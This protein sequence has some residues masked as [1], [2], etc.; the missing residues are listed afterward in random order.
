MDVIATSEFN[1]AV[2]SVGINLPPHMCVSKFGYLVII[3]T[4]PSIITVKFSLIGNI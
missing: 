2:I 4:I 3:I 1:C